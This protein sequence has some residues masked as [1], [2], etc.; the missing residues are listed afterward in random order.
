MR[1]F[2]KFLLFALPLTGMFSC[3][4]PWEKVDREEFRVLAGN[5]VALLEKAEYRTAFDTFDDAMKGAFPLEKLQGTWEG[6]KTQCGSLVKLLETKMEVKGGYLAVVSRYE[7][8]KITI[9]L[10]IV[11]NIKK[12]ISGFWISEDKPEA[13][14]RDPPYAKK[15]TFTEKEVTVGS[16]E[17]E[18]PG[19]L[20]VPASKG[21]FPAVILVHG[22]GPNDRDE[23]I[24][25]ARVFR[26]LAWGLASNGIA[27]LRYEKRTKYYQNKMASLS[28]TL[29]VKEETIDDVLEAVN[30]LSNMENIRKDALFIAGHSLGG[31]VIPR[32][33]ELT[34]KVTGYICMAGTPRPMED[35]ILEQ[36]EYIFKSDG[37][38]TDEEKAN[39]AII[40]KQVDKVKDPNL[41]PDTPKEELPLGVNAAYWID[42]KKYDISQLAAKMSRPVFIIRGERDYQVTEK[43]FIAWKKAFEGSPNAE[44]KEY[45]GLNH[46]F[47]KGTGKSVPAE[48]NQTGN[49]AEEVINDM[50]S[51]I[52]KLS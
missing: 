30:L 14:F 11:Y 41:S 23:T 45:P 27:V 36:S 52:K 15:D 39:L 9:V 2:C 50:T 7:F 10:R 44:F 8:E 37:E 49:V 46:L 35:L 29:T 19:T 4:D 38:L 48:Y 16:G 17:W 21:P 47:I 32:I 25:G 1:N 24:G 12:E 5:F 6:V 43:D 51:W 34:D 31:S 26:D 18:L 42:M 33:A 40:K 28:A 13:V 3:G 20:T 22:S